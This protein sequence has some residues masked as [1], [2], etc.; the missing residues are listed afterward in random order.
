[1]ISFVQA[2]QLNDLG[3]AIEKGE[4][5][6]KTSQSPKPPKNIPSAKPKAIQ[7]PAS[8]KNE[9][10]FEPPV[11]MVQFKQT[12]IKVNGKDVVIKVP[13][14]NPAFAKKNP[15]DKRPARIT[16]KPTPRRIGGSKKGAKAVKNG[17]YYEI[18]CS[19]EL[20]GYPLDDTDKFRC[21]GEDK[22]YE[23]YSLVGALTPANYSDN[24]N[25]IYMLQYEIMEKYGKYPDIC[26]LAQLYCND[27][28]QKYA[29]DAGFFKYQYSTTFNY[30]R[31]S[32]LGIQY[33]HLK[34]TNEAMNV[35]L[36]IIE[37]RKKEMKAN[38][39]ALIEKNKE[40]EQQITKYYEEIKKIK[41]AQHG[42][43]TDE[44]MNSFAYD[45]ASKY[46]YICYNYSQMYENLMTANEKE[47]ADAIFK[48][49]KKADG[50]ALSGKLYDAYSEV[51]YETPFKY[52]YSACAPP[53]KS[54]NAPKLPP[55]RDCPYGEI[56]YS[57]EVKVKMYR[58]AEMLLRIVKESRS[59]QALDKED[60]IETDGRSRNER[61]TLDL[62]DY[63]NDFKP[64][65][66]DESKKIPPEKIS[67]DKLQYYKKYAY[68]PSESSGYEDFYKRKPYI[69]SPY[70][71]SNENTEIPET[72]ILLPE[73]YST[74]RAAI[75]Y[76]QPYAPDYAIQ[77]KI[78]TVKT[79][80][81]QDVPVP[82]P[83]PLPD[84]TPAPGPATFKNSK[85]EPEIDRQKFVALIP[86][87][88]FGGYYSKFLVNE[89][90]TIPPSQEPPPV[91][92]PNPIPSPGPVSKKNTK[93]VKD[94]LGK[95]KV[96]TTWPCLINSTKDAEKE[97]ICYIENS[98]DEDYLGHTIARSFYLG[99]KY[100]VN[101]LNASL[102]NIRGL[103]NNVYSDGDNIII[104]K[105]TRE[106]IKCGGMQWVFVKSGSCISTEP[107]F[108]RCLYKNQAD[109][110]IISAHGALSTH[111][112]HTGGIA[113]E[114]EYGGLDFSISPAEFITDINTP[115]EKSEYSEDVD[116]LVLMTC[117]SLALT[118]D[119]NNDKFARGWHKVL[120]KGVILGL[121]GFT[122]GDL[123]WH[124][125]KDLNNYL[126]EL[127]AKGQKATPSGLKEFWRSKSEA[128][129]NSYMS[130]KPQYDSLQ[131]S[132]NAT[133]VYENKRYT[134]DVIENTKVKPPKWNFI[135]KSPD[136]L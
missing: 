23:L 122:S 83:T 129:Y 36:D 84:P 121:D 87:A 88:L 106:S 57:G 78:Y 4:I 109:W 73:E 39:Q 31:Y 26:A 111:A 47:K 34:G 135:E 2:G 112:G 7:T 13:F 59:Y 32:Q 113:I 41:E 66:G 49:E 120:P 61:R 136:T 97:S 119:S 98:Y 58:D 104:P 45:I 86:D 92:T 132:K 30:F 44:A 56:A 42:K 118:F 9:T 117:T 134:Y 67:D 77:A 91:P 43:P 55:T 6:D 74:I 12:K 8:K 90:N 81:P 125:T 126:N 46:S 48:I 105:I 85:G 52:S 128:Y 70:F 10:S 1:M 51:P 64:A 15:P 38:D 75:D 24:M 65:S 89:P 82:D 22:V 79:F 16:E 80:Q 108:K 21:A 102:R 72:S 14:I 76:G 96:E 63:L 100:F 101:R 53:P 62:C 29:K 99:N 33:K 115:H 71:S 95:T 50:Y 123:N 103:F 133:V 5:N 40:Y 68:S 130:G 116:V 27:A 127:V 11:N 124:L 18:P 28:F 35:I 54:S 131:H 19:Y 20:F 3:S 110:L 60:V 93:I 37:D 107:T 25:A 114:N 17:K 94:R 69:K